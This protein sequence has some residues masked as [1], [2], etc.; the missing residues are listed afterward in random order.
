[1][2]DDT[3]G[4]DL[5]RERRIR[6]AGLLILGGLAIEVLCMGPAD[7]VSF[8]VFTGI[9]GMAIAAGSILLIGALLS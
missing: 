7:P 2:I 9:G 6:R 8:V 4:S 3:I 5:R 1:M